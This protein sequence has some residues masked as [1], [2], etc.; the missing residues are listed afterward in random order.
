MNAYS[1]VMSY[2]IFRTPA[3][4]S[5]HLEAHSSARV[6]RYISQWHLAFGTGTTSH[7]AEGHFHIEWTLEDGIA[8]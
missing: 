6:P 5:C 1:S 3:K 2:V 8:R 7:Y 4:P